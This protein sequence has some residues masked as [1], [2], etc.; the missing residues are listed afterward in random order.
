VCREGYR[1]PTAKNQET[2]AVNYSRPSISRLLEANGYV[3]GPQESWAEVLAGALGIT[4]WELRAQLLSGELISNLRAQVR[5]CLQAEPPVGIEPVADSA[6]AV[7]EMTGN[8]WMTE[9]PENS[10]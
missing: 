1:P 2:G 6:D 4:T 5:A 10:Q 3:R 9:L 7:Q 8:L